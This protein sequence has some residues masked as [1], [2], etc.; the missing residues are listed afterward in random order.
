MRVRLFLVSA[1]FAGSV[2]FFISS[3]NEL[4]EDKQSEA[5]PLLS[6]PVNSTLKQRGVV[7]NTTSKN[8]KLSSMKAEAAS[9][10]QSAQGQTLITALTAFWQQCNQEP[11]CDDMLLQQQLLLDEDRYQLLLN[12]P[13]SLQAEQRLMGASLISHD[14]SLADKITNVQAI[15]EQVWGEDA[16][17]LFK[18]QDDY[19]DYRLSLLDPNSRFNR[20]QD[21]DDFISEY[22]KMLVEQG[23]DLTRV[24]LSTDTAKYEEALKLIPSTMPEDQAVRIKDELAS[25]Y[26][27]ANEQQSIR[28]REQQIDAQ[29]QDITDYQQGLNQL[30]TNLSNERDTTKKQMTNADWHAYK[31]ER[32]YQYRLNFFGP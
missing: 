16:A 25:Q 18:Q 3:E 22:N 4:N 21:A 1:A 28:H 27:T 30:Q 7:S 14:T 26:L 20:S 23:D 5:A 17:L 32:L 10:L 13:E 29:N 15:R 2:Y 6:A 24:A 11:H 9:L 19:Y 8:I 31:A 12:F